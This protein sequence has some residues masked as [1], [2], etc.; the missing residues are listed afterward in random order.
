MPS[1][2]RTRPT[3]SPTP[4][5]FPAPTPVPQV[6]DSTYAVY[7]ELDFGDATLTLTQISVSAMESVAK[8]RRLESD[9]FLARQGY[10]S[11]VGVRLLLTNYGEEHVNLGSSTGRAYLRL[12]GRLIPWIYPW[13]SGAFPNGGCHEADLIFGIRERA[14]D[15]IGTLTFELNDETHG[16]FEFTFDLSKLEKQNG[17]ERDCLTGRA[18]R[19]SR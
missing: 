14:P 8:G 16:S 3:P 1:P 15:E 13:G 6:W 2:T 12:G 7:K 9:S 11:I 19:R 10:K 4:L 18:S 5:Y 17:L